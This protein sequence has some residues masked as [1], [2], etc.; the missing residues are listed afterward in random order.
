MCCELRKWRK[1]QN[2]EQI[3]PR[4]MRREGWSER[5]SF[6][7]QL[8]SRF[9]KDW[10]LPQHSSARLSSSS[11]CPRLQMPDGT[12]RELAAEFLD[13]FEALL[14]R[15]STSILGNRRQATRKGSSQIL[16][17]PLLARLRINQ[18]A[19]QVDAGSLATWSLVLRKAVAPARCAEG[20]ARR[21]NMLHGVRRGAPDEPAPPDL[22]GVDWPTFLC[23]LAVG[24]SLTPVG[25]ARCKVGWLDGSDFKSK[26]AL[27]RKVR[28]VPLHWPFG[29]ACDVDWRR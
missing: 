10:G 24:V 15:F 1:Y 18:W 23:N 21:R 14:V 4:D 16:A 12:D 6:Y 26:E 28:D 19:W 29:R 8:L 7:Q 5:Q 13:L 25:K 17:N 22:S 9:M 3:D 11:K 2:G 20:W 27:L